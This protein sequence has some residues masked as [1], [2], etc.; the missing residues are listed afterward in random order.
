[1]TDILDSG[2][3]IILI[4]SDHFW[5]KSPLTWLDKQAGFDIIVE[6]NGIPPKRSVCA[7]FLFLNNTNSTRQLWYKV[8]R[9][10]MFFRS[11]PE[12]KHVNEQDVIARTLYENFKETPYVSS[13]NTHIL[14]NKREKRRVYSKVL[15]LWNTADQL[16]PPPEKLT[17]C[18]FPI[19]SIL[20]GNEQ[21]YHRMA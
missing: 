6:N 12:T 3:S 21:L 9:H 18:F 11:F 16:Y 1:M 4:D 10:T 8:D 7:G 14:Q 20:S 19:E 5:T 2:S 13:I 17:W 15:E